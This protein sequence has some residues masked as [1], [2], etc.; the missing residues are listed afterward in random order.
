MTRVHLTRR[1]RDPREPP[2]RPGVPKTVNRWLLGALRMLVNGWQPPR[3]RA[4]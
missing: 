2:R 4:S 1:A 3:R